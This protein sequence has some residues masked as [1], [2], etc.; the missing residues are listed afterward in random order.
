MDA[1]TGKKIRLASLLDPALGGAVI[2]AA[3]HGEQSVPPQQ[4][5]T[6]E[7][8][9][10]LF[11]AL[12]GADGVM[13]APG[14]LPLVEDSYLGKDAPALVVHMDWKN[15]T[16]G[17]YRPNTDGRGEPVAA[18]LATVEE[19]SSA[20]ASAIM[21][22]L[23]VGHTDT[24]LNERRSSA[25]CALFATATALASSASSNRV[26][27][28]STSTRPMPTVSRWSG[29]TAGLRRRSVPTW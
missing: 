3:S 9:G 16:R 18:S 26:L 27:H 14:L 8:I 1:R 2:V 19:V 20:G 23:H 22:Y 28:T 25:T 15:A 7:E 6:R 4:M 29:S 21:T 10:T 11:R 12:R 13:V 24:T 5:G 17:V